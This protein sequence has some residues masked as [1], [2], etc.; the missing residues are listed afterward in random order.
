MPPSISKKMTI[1]PYT[2]NL[3]LQE[4]IPLVEWNDQSYAHIWVL[5]Q[6]CPLLS[7]PAHLKAFA[8][9]SNFLWKAGQFQCIDCIADYQTH[10]VEQ[11]KLEKKHPGDIFP[12]RLTDYKIFDVSGMHNPR[13]ENGNLIYYVYNTANGLPY[14]VI[15]PFPYTG[16]ST[17]VHY[18]ILPIKE[19]ATLT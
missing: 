16:N 5:V 2:M 3:L 8:E 11:V 9:I 4:Q 15:C 7:D 18:Q 17:L 13:L 10:Y 19:E 12:Y 6:H 1:G 14:R